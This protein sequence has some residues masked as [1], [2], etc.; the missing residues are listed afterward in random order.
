MAFVIVFV[1]MSTLKLLKDKSMDQSQIF[2]LFII[3]VLEDKSMYQSQIFLLFIIVVSG[4]LY[5]EGTIH[6]EQ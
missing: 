1:V 2:L 3:A 6:M 5:P 4:Y